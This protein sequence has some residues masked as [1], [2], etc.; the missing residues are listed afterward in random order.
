MVHVFAQRSSEIKL[1]SKQ[2][3]QD[4]T[5]TKS[6]KINDATTIKIW[7]SK[8]MHRTLG[9]F[10]EEQQKSQ[11]NNRKSVSFLSQRQQGKN[12]HPWFHFRSKV[13][14]NF[15]L[16]WLYTF[17]WE[18]AIMYQWIIH[19]CEQ[20][21]NNDNTLEGRWISVSWHRKVD[22]NGNIG[23]YAFD[24]GVIWFSCLWCWSYF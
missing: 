5:H 3:K 16:G 23:F 1:S 7:W 19:G 15:L 13:F 20:A 6:V 2:I 4:D 18:R 12:H 14:S 10:S 21:I 11:D 22:P 24:V 17:A 8:K 9:W